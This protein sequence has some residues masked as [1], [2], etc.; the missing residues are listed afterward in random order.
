MGII[1]VLFEYNMD[2][3]PKLYPNHFHN[4]SLSY[5]YHILAIPKYLDYI[6][7]IK[8]R[9]FGKDNRRMCCLLGERFLRS[10]PVIR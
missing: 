8:F 3:R 9:F 6:C 10:Y 1:W 4:I 2:L 7:I 5:P